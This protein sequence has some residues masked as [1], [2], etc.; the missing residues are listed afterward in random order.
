MQAPTPLTVLPEAV[1]ARGVVI[2]CFLIP[3][4]LISWCSLKKRLSFPCFS[5]NHVLSSLWA[6]SLG[7][8]PCVL[9]CSRYSFGCPHLAPGSHMSAPLFEG[10]QNFLTL[11]HRSCFPGGS[12]RPVSGEGVRGCD[13][14]PCSLHGSS[15]TLSLQCP[16]GEAFC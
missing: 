4:T 16:G 9:T 15:S 7:F 6:W 1:I 5:L 10:S 12:L 2:F 8:I 3:S 11:W 13:P 14:S